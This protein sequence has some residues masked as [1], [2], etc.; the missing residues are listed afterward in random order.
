MGQ[1]LY[2][3]VFHRLKIYFWTGKKAVDLNLDPYHPYKREKKRSKCGSP[4][5]RR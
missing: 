2:L 1:I 3:L 5:T 4:D